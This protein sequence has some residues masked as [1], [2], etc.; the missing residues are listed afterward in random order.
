M[1][2]MEVINGAVYMARVD[3]DFAVQNELYRSRALFQYLHGLIQSPDIVAG[4]N[5]Q[6]KSL[7]YNVVRADG[8]F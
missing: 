7:R 6:F 8:N 1:V 3:K 2:M 4:T 5:L